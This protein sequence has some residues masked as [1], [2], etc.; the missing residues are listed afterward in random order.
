M[1]KVVTR[2]YNVTLRNSKTGEETS[3]IAT[4]E[5]GGPSIRQTMGPV[6]NELGLELINAE[7]I[8]ALEEIK[9]TPDEDGIVPNQ[10]PENVQRRV[11]K[12]GPQQPNMQFRP[13]QQR[14]AQM[15]MNIPEKIIQHGDVRLKMAGDKVFIEEWVEKEASDGYKIIS[16]DNK[17]ITDQVTILHKEWVELKEEK[18]PDPEPESEPIVPAIIDE[19]V[20]D[21]E[22]V[23]E[24]DNFLKKFD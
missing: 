22:S 18:Q 1:P 12:Q 8:E 15:P 2:K 21:V 14:G 19:N 20:D 9:I 10:S 17:I 23:N 6:W 4:E 5:V 16:K 11:I 24:I 7:L 3:T 13:P